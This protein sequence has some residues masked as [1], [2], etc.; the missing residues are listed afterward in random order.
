MGRS[1]M[2]RFYESGSL[3]PLKISSIW[4]TERSMK[5]EEILQQP[6]KNI[7]GIGKGDYFCS[8][9]YWSDFRAGICEFTDW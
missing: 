4:L 6:K 8:L 3:G 7:E 5:L 1:E 2:L 9:Y